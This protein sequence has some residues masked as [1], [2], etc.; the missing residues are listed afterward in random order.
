MAMVF[1]FIGFAGSAFNEHGKGEVEVGDGLQVGSY[2][3]HLKEIQE[4]NN[5]NYASQTAR[6]EVYRNG[7]LLETMLPERRSYHASSTGT[8]EVAIRA[9]MDEDV[10]VVFA[11]ISTVTNKPVLEVYVNPL[12]NWIWVGSFVLVF[13]T[14]I[15][16]VPSKIKPIRTRVLGANK[17]PHEIS[18]NTN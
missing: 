14:L 13:G 17:E 15:A 10:Y 3:F 1:M 6:V 4:E 12:V 2:E 7:E 9:S 11:G 18:A 8:T 5:D 16:L